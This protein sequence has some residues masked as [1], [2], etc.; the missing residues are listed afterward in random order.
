MAF[1]DELFTNQVVAADP[2]VPIVTSGE[3]NSVAVCAHPTN[4]DYVW[5]T[6][7]GG[8]DSD[9]WPLAAGQPL[10]IDFRNPGKVYVF[11][12]GTDKLCVLGAF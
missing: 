1:S 6:T 2:A 9:G 8:D 3:S 7:E 10:T 5:I 4:T 11:G 12:N